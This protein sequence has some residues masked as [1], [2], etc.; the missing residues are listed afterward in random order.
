MTKRRPSSA[1]PTTLLLFMVASAA[2]CSGTEDAAPKET[3]LHH[4]QTCQDKLGQIP[5]WAC[6][7]GVQIPVQ[8]DG[9]LVTT[10]PDSCDNPDLKGQC[11]VGSYVGHLAGQNLDGSPKPEVNWVYFCRKDDNFAQMIGYDQSSGASC[12]FELQ[13]GYMPLEQGVP[14]GTVPGVDS[15]DYERAWKR[16]EQIAVQGCN[17]CHSPDPFIHTP[18]IDAVRRPDD[19]THPLLPELATPTSPYYVPGEA[20][21]RWTFDYVAFDDNAC[22]ACHR[23]PDFRRFT[24]GSGVDYDAHMPPLSPGS[25]KADFDAV[26]TCLNQGPDVTPGCHW[27]ALNGATPTGT[28]DKK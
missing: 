26:M 14:K 10:T 11:A 16:P 22:T 28:P 9:K 17:F 5:T 4:A 13:D 8:V 20:F 27:A 2:A 24:F 23:V 18:F 15:P 21:A 6:Q 3:A 12:F 1:A 7:D 25:M 19:P